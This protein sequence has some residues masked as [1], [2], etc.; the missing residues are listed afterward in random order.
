MKNPLSWDEKKNM[1]LV[2][3]K[4]GNYPLILTEKKIYLPVEGTVN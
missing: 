4:C 3:L 2:I 1:I